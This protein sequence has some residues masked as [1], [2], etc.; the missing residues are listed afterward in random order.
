MHLLFGIFPKEFCDGWAEWA[1]RG[2]VFHLHPED[3]ASPARSA[4][5]PHRPGILR[6]STWKRAPGD[7]LVESVFG[8]LRIPLDLRIGRPFCHPVR[9]VAVRDTDGF[10]M[11]HKSRQILEFMP[12]GV[13]ILRRAID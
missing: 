5:K 11:I 2:A 12:E 8:D 3:C 1:R 10:N 7:Q 13:E 4:L 6:I 9:P